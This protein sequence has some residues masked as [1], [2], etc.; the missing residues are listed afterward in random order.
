[1]L[2]SEYDIEYRAQEAVKGSILVD[3]L[4]YQPINKYQSLKFD[5]HDEDVMYLKMKDC[6]ELLPEEGPDPESTRGLIFDGVVNFF[7]NGIGA[8]I[9][10]PEDTHI[11]FSAKLK[12]F[13]FRNFEVSPKRF[14]LV[15]M[16]LS[17]SD[18]LKC[19]IAAMTCCFEMA[20]KPLK[21]TLSETKI[22]KRFA[23]SSK[24]GI[25]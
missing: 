23:Y 20:S 11:P 1:M 21:D 3:H 10:T 13:S 9:I 6:D 7:G 22:P 8:D 19:V 12:A 15:V 25:N 4:A 17:I 18:F 14:P 5:F 16:F 2:L 24:V